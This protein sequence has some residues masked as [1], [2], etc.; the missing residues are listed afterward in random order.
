M[1][2]HYT[3]QMTRGLLSSGGNHPPAESSCPYTG[4]QASRCMCDLMVD[5]L[6]D[7]RSHQENGLLWWWSQWERGAP[8]S[9]DCP[10]QHVKAPLFTFRPRERGFPHPF[11]PG[12]SSCRPDFMLFGMKATE[13]KK[14]ELEASQPLWP[15]QQ[16]W[17]LSHSLVTW[18]SRRRPINLA[19]TQPGQL[20]AAPSCHSSLFYSLTNW[21]ALGDG[22]NLSMAQ[23]PSLESADDKTC[24]RELLR[25]KR[26][27]T[28]QADSPHL[29]PNQL[30]E[31]VS[32]LSLLCWTVCF[33][34]TQF[35]WA[36][37][38]SAFLPTLE[39][40]IYHCHVVSCQ[41]SCPRNF[42]RTN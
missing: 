16:A 12:G 13:W 29:R 30:P 19:E 20:A 21:G 17:A 38:C 27:N 22:F 41:F 34:S 32:W 6:T 23:F 11:L 37:Y 26:D 33:L 15:R 10:R 28:G 4:A 8:V 40:G 7:P 18:I 1:I 36:L 5:S 39:P 25:I 2:F 31:M 14:E 42:R 3:S 24:L 35:F 9:T